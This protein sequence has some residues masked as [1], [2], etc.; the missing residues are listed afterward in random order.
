MSLTLL[1]NSLTAAF[2]VYQMFV[3]DVFSVID[4]MDTLDELEKQP[5]NEKYKP[6][7]SIHL[8]SVTIHANPLAG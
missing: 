2:S 6:L 4:G 5:V 1:P 7:N 8:N 3:C